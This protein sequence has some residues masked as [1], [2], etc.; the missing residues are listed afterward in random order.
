MIFKKVHNNRRRVKADIKI[1]SAK[2]AKLLPIPDVTGYTMTN[3]GVL[4]GYKS[5]SV[6]S[7]I[8]FFRNSSRFFSFSRRL[9]S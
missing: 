6:C 3:L 2:I 9:R 7:A 5:I 1:A 8:Y 4:L